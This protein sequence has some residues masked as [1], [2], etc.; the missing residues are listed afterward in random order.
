MLGKKGVGKWFGIFGGPSGCIKEENVWKKLYSSVFDCT[1]YTISFT[2][3]LFTKY[4]NLLWDYFQFK[5]KKVQQYLWTPSRKSVLGQFQAHRYHR[6]GSPVFE[7]DTRLLFRSHH[8]KFTFP[9]I[10]IVC[11]GQN[12]RIPA[13]FINVGLFRC[14]SISDV[15]LVVCGI[16]WTRTEM[17]WLATWYKLFQ[18]ERYAPSSLHVFFV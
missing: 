17:S 5:V 2:F 8:S 13:Q 4:L 10:M 6:A 3:R 15:V 11:S 18:S 14:C 7:P 16:H 12:C 9:R 1:Q